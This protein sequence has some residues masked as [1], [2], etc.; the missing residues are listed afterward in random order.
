M[1]G[2]GLG[3]ESGVVGWGLGLEWCSVVG[4]GLGLESGVVMWGGGGR[5][6]EW[7]SVVMWGG[8]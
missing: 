7:C 3:L 5:I 1:W 6:G 8:G 4:W 2:G